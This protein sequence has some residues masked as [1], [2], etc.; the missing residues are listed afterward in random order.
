MQIVKLRDKPGDA[1]RQMQPAWRHMWN[2]V[3]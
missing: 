1:A 3:D 2:N